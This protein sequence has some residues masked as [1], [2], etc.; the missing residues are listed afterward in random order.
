MKIL[1][2]IFLFLTPLMTHAQ[3]QLPDSIMSKMLISLED[4]KWGEVIG[5]F[6]QFA[7]LDPENA[8]V[9]YWVRAS[10]K[11]ALGDTLLVSLADIY[12]H[13]GNLDKS[14]SL[15][16][17]YCKGSRSFTV[18]ELLTLAQRLTDIG[19][20]RLTQ[21]LYRQVIDLDVNN[22]NANLFLGNYIYLRAEKER[23]RLAFNY[24]RKQ[25]PTHMEYVEY[26]NKLKDLYN[27]SFKEAEV[28]LTRAYA[29]IKSAEI[30]RMLTHIEKLKD[31][32]G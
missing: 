6:H 29:K 5:L 4:E 3:T 28:Y 21:E 16:K 27:F 7:N 12:Y 26:R 22:L 14:L 19:E 23:R 20:V 18:N 9:F 31:E 10:D 15:Y 17:E 1:L 24:K 32:L 11:P 8:E 13:K 2:L 25:K 30:R